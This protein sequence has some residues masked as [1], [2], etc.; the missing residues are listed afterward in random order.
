MKELVY[1]G[2]VLAAVGFLVA[3][4][5]VQYLLRYCLRAD[6]DGQRL[7]LKL[8]LLGE[9]V[10]TCRPFAQGLR[11]EEARQI[12]RVADQIGRLI[13]FDVVMDYARRFDVT[14]IGFEG[15]MPG[16]GWTLGRLAY[17]SIHGGYS[18][19]LNPELDLPLV[20]RELS[21]QLQRPMLPDDV[22][23]FLFFHE[24]GHST[25]AGN[26][27]YIAAQVQNSL[28]GG[29]R[30]TRRRRELRRLHTRI[31]RFADDFA[32]KELVRYRARLANRRTSD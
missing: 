17:S 21:H 14:H 19:S 16:G 9:I 11:V 1:L 15:D 3:V 28:S 18:I 6:L 24:V 23:P 31:E 20:A 30:T 29:R 27:C 12:L 5:L 13:D 10:T 2:L 26:Q 7:V 8:P 4:G 25:K 32:W 22:Y